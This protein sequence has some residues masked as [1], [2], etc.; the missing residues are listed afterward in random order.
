MVVKDKKIVPNKN[1]LIEYRKNYL[2]TQK[3]SC[4]SF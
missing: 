4:N 3:V 2:E 1:M